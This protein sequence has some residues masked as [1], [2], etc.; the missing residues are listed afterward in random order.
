MRVKPK[1]DQK[2]TNPVRLIIQLNS[3]QYSVMSIKKKRFI[4][5]VLLQPLIKPLKSCLRFTNFTSY[6]F[7]LCYLGSVGWNSTPLPSL[8]GGKL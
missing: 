2:G 7:P 5:K 6:F 8:G 3:S 4:F 1:I